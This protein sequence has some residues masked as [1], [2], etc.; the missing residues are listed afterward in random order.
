MRCPQR[1]GVS[2]RCQEAW[3][4]EA[5]GECH[6][7]SAPRCVPSGLAGPP[8]CRHRCAAPQVQQALGELNPRSWCTS[9]K[10]YQC[11]WGQRATRQKPV[12]LPPPLAARSPAGCPEAGSRHSAQLSSG[13]ASVS[14]QLWVRWA[15]LRGP[16]PPW[17]CP[18]PFQGGANWQ[19]WNPWHRLAE[20]P[21]W[22][23]QPLCCGI[24][25]PERRTLTAQTPEGTC[26]P[27]LPGVLLGRPLP[28][29]SA[30]EGSPAGQPH[31]ATWPLA[32][33]RR[34]GHS[35]QSPRVSGRRTWALSLWLRASETGCLRAVAPAPP[36]PSE[37]LLPEPSPPDPLLWRA[38][39]T[40]LLPTS[41][42]PASPQPLLSVH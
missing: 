32:T 23:Q 21:P 29:L 8:P 12:A 18:C 4:G 3:R 20:I 42:Q 11:L 22:H 30:S 14:P 37:T 27:G 15:W 36:P 39:R 10:L 25:P 40:C 19:G 31:T 35:R 38:P 24:L 9:W 28:S 17:P 33:T 13:A 34:R 16:H 26:R 1:V 7:A 5:G 6:R 41:L 2:G